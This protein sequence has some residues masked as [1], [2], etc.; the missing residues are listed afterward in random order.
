MNNVKTLHAMHT[1]P[2]WLEHA[3]PAAPR[4]G[5]LVWALVVC[6]WLATL[7]LGSKRAWTLALL[8]MTVFG[9]CLLAAW[10]W[11]RHP[12]QALARLAR[13]RWPL[14]LL[15]ALAGWMALQA[16]PL[17][18][19]VV[20]LL[21]PEAWRVQQGVTAAFTLSLEPQQTRT[22]AVFAFA[23]A[24]VFALVV[25]TL[26]ERKRLDALVMGLVLVGVF[27]AL[28]AVFLWSVQARYT[29]LHF[30][31]VHLNALG[32]F[33]NRNHLA[34]FLVMVLSLGIGLMVARLGAEGPGHASHWRGRLA[35]V[36]AFVLSDKM[37][38]RLM[39]VVLV[40]ALVLTRSRMG[41]TSFFV[42]LLCMGA[43]TLLLVRRSSRSLMV[44]VASL[45][46]ID[47]VVVGTW[48]GLE[49]VVE[50]MQGTEMLIEQ[51][52]TQE[53]M[54]Q[55]QLAATQALALVQDFALTGTGAGT[56]Y[57]SFIRYRA[58]GTHFFDHAHND[59]VE[60]LSDWGVVGVGLLGLL[61]VV[62]ALVSLRSLVSRRL[63]MARGMAFG[64][65][66]AMLALAIHS[67][68]D[69]NLHIPANA[70]LIVVTLAVGWAAA[71]LP[72][73]G[74]MDGECTLK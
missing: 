66:M 32:T 23:L 44:L 10:L 4:D 65:L 70:L 24:L 2:G 74:S 60:L 48:V 34:G 73:G 59:Y 40:I 20:Q 18:G 50:R 26:R 68:V 49:K 5:V 64:G 53:S 67:S 3:A 16:L 11:R 31:V 45:V 57:G 52:G 36:L 7:P 58:P 9:M 19:F 55:R 71:L 8:V 41:N 51:G 42:A 47:V 63:P 33:G 39:L 29:V 43:L 22:Q 30:N 1:A 15:L 37:R 35:S 28:L 62:S 69:F 54:E 21:S 61:V 27:Q 56:F 72:S 6:V 25:L 46:L 14:G 38:L 13:V 12:A 17:P